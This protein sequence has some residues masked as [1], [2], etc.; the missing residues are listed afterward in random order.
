MRRARCMIVYY[1]VSHTYIVL[2]REDYKTVSFCKS[3]RN[4]AI[5]SEQ[6]VQKPWVCLGDK[7]TNFQDISTHPSPPLGGK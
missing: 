6:L 1:Y 5:S 4:L 3:M 7:Q 2:A